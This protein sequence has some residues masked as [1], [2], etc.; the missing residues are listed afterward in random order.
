MNSY[1]N[2]STH[3]MAQL[4]YLTTTSVVILSYITVYWYQML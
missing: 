3:C 2:K 1:S 4:N